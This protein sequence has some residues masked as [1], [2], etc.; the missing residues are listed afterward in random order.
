MTQKSIRIFIN[1]IYSKPPK[2]NYLKTKHM[3]T[4]VMTYGVQIF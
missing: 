3:F 4:K 1:E 2:Q